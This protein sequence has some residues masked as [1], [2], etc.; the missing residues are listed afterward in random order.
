MNTGGVLFDFIAF[1]HTLSVFLNVVLII[2]PSFFLKHHCRWGTCSHSM[3]NSVYTG[4]MERHDNDLY[5]IRTLLF[6]LIN[7]IVGK[8]M[9][10]YK[11]NF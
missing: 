5:F 9:L 2:F 11:L 3:C 8:N 7:L 6:I 1:V 4:E 10:I